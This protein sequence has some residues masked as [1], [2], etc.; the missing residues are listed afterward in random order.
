MSWVGRWEISPRRLIASP[1]HCP[2]MTISCSPRGWSMTAALLSCWFSKRAAISTWTRRPNPAAGT[3][4]LSCAS[5]ACCARP[6]CLRACWSARKPSAWSMLRKANRAATSPSRLPI[7][8]R[9]R[10]GPCWPPCTC[11][12]PASGC[13]AWR[14]NNATR[15]PFV[16]IAD[17][18]GF[19]FQ[20]A[21]Q[22]R[23]AAV[24]V[25]AI[26]FEL[27]E[28][29]ERQHSLTRYGVEEART[30]QDVDRLLGPDSGAV[31][32]IVNSVCG[33][34]AGRARPAIGLALQHAVRPSKVAT[35]FAGGDE[36]AVAHLR[37]RLSDYPPSSPSM[38]LSQDGKPVYMLHRSEIDGRTECIGAEWHAGE[39]PGRRRV[40]LPGAAEYRRR[41]RPGDNHP[42]PRVR[43][44]PEFHPDHHAARNYPAAGSAG[45]Q[46]AGLFKRPHRRG[47]QYSFVG[48]A[49]G[50]N[51]SGVDGRAEFRDRRSA[52]SE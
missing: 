11:C 52:R 15:T 7:W 43:R 28:F 51:R 34:A 44:P 42:I 6:A 48:L 32:M 49:Q 3:P 19:R 23:Q 5:S 33:C 25:A 2:V 37:A 45:G 20:L 50:E 9:W 41:R 29:I 22:F 21:F 35:V 26:G 38:A 24:P 13:S 39:L 27:A 31:L 17:A 8:C 16:Y 36:A 40:S 4:R 30:P 46:F 18:G 47:L 14:P 12:S 10:A 1:S